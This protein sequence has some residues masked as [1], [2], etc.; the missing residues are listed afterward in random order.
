M[1]G[2][3]PKMRD[4]YHMIEKV[5]PTEATVLIV[6][7][8][9]SGKELAAHTIHRMSARASGPFVA[10]NCGAIPATLI[11]AELFGYEKGAFTGATRSHRGFFE[12]A[13]GG[14]LFLDE[15]TEM[16]PEMQVRLL[17]VLD[18]GRFCRVG[19]DCE[20]QSKVRVIAAT[21]RNPV[22]AVEENHLREDLMYRLAVFP[23]H[24]PP[25]RARGDDVALLAR[26]L[27]EEMN[28]EAGT[29]K[30]LTE[31]SL[32]DIEGYSWPGNVRELKNCIQRAFI[33][34]EAEVNVELPLLLARQANPVAASSDCLQ[35][36]IGT[37]LSDMERTTILATLN[38]CS[39]DK[40]RTAEVLG[41]SLKTLYNR[42]SEY[43]RTPATS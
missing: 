4:V 1:Y 40:R 23:I 18:S 42:L 5:A 16:A 26:H 31:Q 25:L 43:G 32:R 36:E 14:T 21:N 19:G 38:Q 10:V 15:I 2:A 27:L 12:R 11:E 7:E 35:F 29:A 8:S 9:G 20:I 37:S 30:R 3:S 28:E 13:E 24:L 33:L 22:T 6:G 34:A 39:G 41:V 17:R